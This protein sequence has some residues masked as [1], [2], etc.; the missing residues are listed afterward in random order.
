[1]KFLD[2]I[3]YVCRKFD[4]RGVGY[5]LI[6]GFGMAM[7]GVQ[8]ATVDLDFIVLLDDLVTADD[9][10]VS[11]GYR[12]SFHSEN[13]SH[14]RSEDAD[15]GRIDLV[16]AFRGPSLSML[17]RAERIEVAGGISLPVARTEDIVG[18]KIQAAFN[19]PAR[20][21]QDWQ[22]IRLLV[23][24]AAQVGKALDWELITDYLAIFEQA[25]KLEEIRSWY[26]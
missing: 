7:R 5:A 23:Q 3:G 17:E 21:A 22:D 24:A 20:S 11:S 1:M 10:L 4:S 14:Y 2:V 12:R 6:G 18:L 13:V 26:D 8:R 9:V 16:H 15:F 19:D 25:D